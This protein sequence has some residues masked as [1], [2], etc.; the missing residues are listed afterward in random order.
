MKKLLIIITLSFH[1][2]IYAQNLPDSVITIGNP[3]FIDCSEL[4]NFDMHGGI[5]REYKFLDLTGAPTVIEH[6]LWNEKKVW[7]D[8]DGNTKVVETTGMKILEINGMYNNDDVIT[9]EWEDSDWGYGPFRKTYY[10]R[11]PNTAFL[12]FGKYKDLEKISKLTEK[13]RLHIEYPK[14]PKYFKEN[15][16]IHKIMISFNGKTFSTG[17]G[18]IDPM[19]FQEINKLKKGS[20]IVLSVIAESEYPTARPMNMTLIKD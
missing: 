17:D 10:V 19:V 13:D 6:N 14:T 20:E 16:Q 5:D 12:M 7:Q 8:A 2:I 4:L 9:I 1:G 11:N 18:I 15:F 3:K